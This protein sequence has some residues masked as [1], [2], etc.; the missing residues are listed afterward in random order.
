MLAEEKGVDISVVNQELAKI[1]RIANE[2]R[3]NKS[4]FDEAVTQCG[5]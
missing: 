5:I 3:V 4:N 1:N 2:I